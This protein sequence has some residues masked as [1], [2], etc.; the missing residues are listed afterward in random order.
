MQTPEK[1]KREY[2]RDRLLSLIALAFLAFIFFWQPSNSVVERK[3]SNGNHQ[4]SVKTEPKLLI[5][6]KLLNRS[7]NT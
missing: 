1:L 5:A 4:C 3:G 6:Y 7:L 2:F